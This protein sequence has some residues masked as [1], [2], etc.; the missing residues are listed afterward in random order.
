MIDTH[1]HVFAE[2][3][4][5]SWAGP[6][7]VE[8]YRERRY[9]PVGSAIVIAAG[10]DP[11][12]AL[13]EAVAVRQ[14]AKRV[15][16]IRGYVGEAQLVDGTFDWGYFDSV[17]PLLRGFRISLPDPHIVEAVRED[18][19][20]LGRVPLPVEILSREPEWDIALEVFA[21]NAETTFVIDHCGRPSANEVTE[22]WKHFIKEA[23][24]MPNTV[25]KLSGDDLDAGVRRISLENFGV[26]RAMY[27]SDF[28]VTNQ[29][30]SRSDD[31]AD[32]LSAT[33]ERIYG[34]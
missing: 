32:G 10:A 33:A 31:L 13:A 15:G 5:Y 4:P 28:P 22:E 8:R 16:W 14:Q 21:A 20:S 2:G 25:V 19:W 1:L 26:E 6:E 12:W 18:G 34:V 9:R 23:A 11:G 7:N 24:G 27:G 29:T 30:P 3:I 17:G